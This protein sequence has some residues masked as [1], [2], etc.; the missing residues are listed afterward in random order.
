MSIKD[1][2]IQFIRKLQNLYFVDRDLDG[3]IECLDPDITWIGTGLQDVCRN[4]N[5]ACETLQ[6]EKAQGYEPFVIEKDWYE[7]V[8]LSGSFCF[9]YGEVTVRENSDVPLA[10]RLVARISA[11]CRQCCGCYKLWHIH[12]SSPDRDQG[13]DES[14][15]KII[16]EETNRILKEML[17]RREEE[18]R[19]HMR[20]FQVLTNNIPGGVQQ[21]ENDAHFTI[22]HVSDGFYTMFGYTKEEIHDLFHDRYLEMIHPT[23]RAAVFDIMQDQLQY[24]NMIEA[25]YRVVCKDGR[26]IWVLD[27]GKLTKD[28]TGRE[29]FYCILLDITETRKAQEELRLSLERHQII[30]DQANDIIFEWDL[31]RDALNYSNNWEKKFGYVPVT[32][33][34]STYLINSGNIFAD[35]RPV[36]VEL[37]GAIKRGEAYAE[38]ELRLRQADGAYI[39][40][41]IR[42]TAQFDALGKS[43]KAVGVIVDIDHEK[44]KSQKLLE[45]AERDTLT[46]LYNK[47]TLENL[48]EGCLANSKKGA[49]HCLMIIDIDNFK[50]INDT[51]GHLFGD[52]VLTESAAKFQSLFYSTDMIGRIGGDEFMIFIKEIPDTVFIQ[53]KAEQVLAIFRDILVEQ[54][55]DFKITCSIGIALAPTDGK[56]FQELYLKADHALYFA[57]TK[58]KDRYMLYDEKRMATTFLGIAKAQQTAI[59]ETIDSDGGNSGVNAQLM[60]YVFRILYKSID[61]EAA[62]HLIL[63]LVGRQFDVSRMY[64]FENSEDDSTCSNTFEWCNDG[65][66]SEKHNL[67]NLSYAELGN[68]TANF[69]DN[70]IFYCRDVSTLPKSQFEILASQGIKAL[71]QCSICDNG[72]FKG[73]VG[74]D[75]CRISRYWTQE[76]INAL[77]FIS[78][79]VST[80]LLKKRAQ[81]RVMHA[82]EEMRVILDTQDLW[83]YVIDPDTF[84]LL[85]INQKTR[86]LV[87]E[88]VLGMCCYKAYFNRSTPCEVCPA[89]KAIKNSCTLEIYNPIL[90]IWSSATA[91][92]IDWNGREACMLSC[93]DITKYKNK[94]KE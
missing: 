74:F 57:K 12:L 63:E 6:K 91:S 42:A 72:A 59:N 9:V 54:N 27:R 44:K 43:L 84:E 18:L 52:A 10:M 28:D 64:I 34:I 17:D 24:G 36:I 49:V 7:A 61:I 32:K 41:R 39:W 75:D 62:I 23:D 85:Y 58:G 83:I 56:T 26:S 25:E 29:V 94:S 92:R 76:Q 1:D 48:V 31:A 93:H 68:Y 14:F 88:A 46:K 4:Y 30:M 66:A 79:I 8:P 86:S 81:D 20:D 45:K 82:A 70:G 65:I 2:S 69:D 33:E 13:P 15:P 3:V 80:F 67:Q 73:Y 47:G 53:K 89:R 50:T 19:A 77:S 55:R 51:L 5:Q 38:G 37:M 71:L 35:D 21:C 11:I 40:C 90:H 22:L 16:N 87:P 78:E 60:E